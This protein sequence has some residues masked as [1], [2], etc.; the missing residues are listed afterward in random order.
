MKDKSLPP[1]LQM[2]MRSSVNV[3]SEVLGAL[4]ET[5]ALHALLDSFGDALIVMDGE[6]RVR[7]LNLAA[8]RINRLS[9]QQAVGLSDHDF[10][11]AQR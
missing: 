4:M 2:G 10:F 11:S 3:S 6:G 8:E 1:S 7:F 9:R 5:P